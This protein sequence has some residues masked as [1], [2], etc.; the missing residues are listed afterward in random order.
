MNVGTVFS[1]LYIS[2]VP[3]I[4]G[5]GATFPGLYLQG[6]CVFPKA[7]FGGVMGLHLL[8]NFYFVFIL[9]CRN[10]GRD[11]RKVGIKNNFLP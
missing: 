4:K 11:V 8:R 1:F 9:L 6:I 7:Y 10:Q 2:S 5:N 3:E